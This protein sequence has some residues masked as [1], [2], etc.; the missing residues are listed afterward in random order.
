MTHPALVVEDLCVSYG[1]TA[2]LRNVSLRIEAGGVTGVVGESGCGKSTLILALLGLL[3]PGGRRV[4]GR[5]VLDGTDLTALSP[6]ALNR[7]R[8]DRVSVV[9]QDPMAALSPVLS[10][11]TQMTDIQ[12]RNSGSAAAKRRRA[13]EMLARVRVSDPE[14]RLRQYPHEF[15]GGML[16]RVTIAMAVLARPAL[17]I[18]DE[19]TTALDATTEL[20]I[21][22]LLRE[23]QREVGCAIMLVSHHLGLIAEIS[24]EVAVLYAG[25]VV[26]HGTLDAVFG[27]PR[28][29]YTRRLIAC[30]PARI[31]TRT[32]VLPTI[33][34]EVPNLAALPPGCV[35]A[36]RCD[37]VF[38]P[39]TLQ[40]PGLFH[41]RP[42]HDA[43]C[44]L[45]PEGLRP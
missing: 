14:L 5:V 44:F 43:R 17:L 9:F 1:A 26:E 22:G 42:D 39:C 31:A 23:L 15:S 40:H 37:R 11:G 32:R 3:P 25:E 18:A 30:D 19:P 35:F 34:G 27:D 2:A 41:D 24:R 20:E 21:V 16:Q 8:G 13:A 33:P 7:L 12:Y 28:H 38:A 45:V 6:A 36:P 10:I 29:P 4:A